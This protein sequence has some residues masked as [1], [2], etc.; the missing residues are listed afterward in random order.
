MKNRKIF[1][2]LLFIFAGLALVVNKMGYLQDI[3]IFSLLI[4]IFLISIIVKSIRDRSIFGIL[5]PLSLITIIFK[6]YLGISH[7][8]SWTIIISAV[9]ISTGLSI[10]FK[11]N[12]YRIYSNIKGKKYNINGKFSNGESSFDE[13]KDGKIYIG[14]TFS[15]NI[16]YLKSQDIKNIFLDSTFGAIKVY[17]DNAEMEGDRATVYLKATFSGVEL[18]VPR[19]WQVIDNTSITFGGLNEKNRSDDEKVKTL[20]LQGNVTFGGVEIIYI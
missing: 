12:K 11:P 9:L 6:E 3:N 5:V 10:I 18:Y 15:E 4:T 13:G 17:F 2:G 19:N 20:I 1:T 7:L 16:K 14:A 8:S